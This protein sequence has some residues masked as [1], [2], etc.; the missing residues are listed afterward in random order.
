ME[1]L[2]AYKTRKYDRKFPKQCCSV[3]KDIISVEVQHNAEI[4]ITKETYQPTNKHEMPI[5]NCRYKSALSTKISTTYSH[6][7]MS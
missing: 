1:T 3:D 2:L 4:S 5:K 7:C 6:V